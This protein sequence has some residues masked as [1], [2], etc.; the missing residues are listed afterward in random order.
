MDAL[1]SVTLHSPW[2]ATWL[3]LVTDDDPL[4]D[5]L[6]GYAQAIFSESLTPAA[7]SPHATLLILPIRSA[8]APPCPSNPPAGG[9]P[10]VRTPRNFADEAWGWGQGGRGGGGRTW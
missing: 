10:T 8:P 6:R 9:S 2:E 1:G 7:L 4:L 3:A 5:M